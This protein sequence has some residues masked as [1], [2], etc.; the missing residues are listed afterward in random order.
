MSEPAEQQPTAVDSTPN[1]APEISST[2]EAP[3]VA[4]D[5]GT[6]A[7]APGPASEAVQMLDPKDV[8]MADAPFDQATV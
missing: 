1:P 5:N 7:S 6:P 3:Q 8:Q 2:A 4:Q